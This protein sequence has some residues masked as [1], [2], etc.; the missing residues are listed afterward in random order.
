MRNHHLL[1]TLLMFFISFSTLFANQKF[2][3]LTIGAGDEAYELYGHSGVRVVDTAAQVDFVIDWGVFDFNQPDFYLNFTLGKMLYTTGCWNTTDFITSVK[4]EGKTL[5]SQEILLNDNQKDRLFEQIKYSLQP[6]NRDYYYDFVF[7]NCAT[8]PRDLFEKTLDTVLIYPVAQDSLTFREIIT[9]YQLDKPWYNLLINIVL[10]SRL[11]HIATVRE[12][13]FIPAYLQQNLSHATVIDLL[14][15][16]LLSPPEQLVQIEPVKKYDLQNV[17]LYVFAFLT[18]LIFFLDIHHKMQKTIRFFTYLFFSILIF[19]S[20]LMIFLWGFTDH[21]TTYANYNLL[22]TNPLLLFPLIAYAQRKHKPWIKFTQLYYIL[23]LII[24]AI[25]IIPQ[26]IPNA[27][28][29]IVI[30][31]WERCYFSFR[32]FPKK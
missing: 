8:R 9:S 6:E 15:H 22:W 17:P 30:L 12:Q 3:L 14:S 2:Y 4:A 5:I 28:V 18:I 29:G 32:D 10:G 27:V 7:D 16:P 20:L 21:Q 11:D 13:M 1:L 24:W 26:S 31:M 25:G 19:I 23:F